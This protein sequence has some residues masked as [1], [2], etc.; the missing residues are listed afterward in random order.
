MN[1]F[2]IGFVAALVLTAPA[3]AQQPA[4]PP[5]RVAVGA[6]TAAKPAPAPRALVSRS[7]EPT[8]DQGT[9]ERISAAM[10]SYAAIEVRGGWP[11]LPAGSKLS[12]GDSGA[13]VAT[14]RRRLA[15]T[16]DLAPQAARGD[17]YDQDLVDAVKRFQ[18]R[19]GLPGNG[20][21]GPQN[22]SKQL[23]VLVGNRPLRQLASSLDRLTEPR[24]SPSVRATWWSISRPLTP[25]W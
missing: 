21:I 12:P 24:A 13:D 10:F 20:S 23:N 16:E 11:A 1:T 9:Q 7:A 17:V 2:H 22:F 19:H 5:T 14:L 3:L 4:A 25:N 8:F 6:Q 18:A 15:I